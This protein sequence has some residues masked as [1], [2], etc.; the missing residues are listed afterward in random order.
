M[1][2]EQATAESSSGEK[3]V[4]QQRCFKR[5]RMSSVVPAVPLD[6]ELSDSE[7]G[8]QPSSDRTRLTLSSPTPTTPDVEIVEVSIK[9]T[10][11]NGDDKKRMRDVCSQPRGDTLQIYNNMSHVIINL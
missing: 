4:G 1:Q 10:P 7:P 3:D 5:L 8:S 6:L 11:N 9:P 2:A